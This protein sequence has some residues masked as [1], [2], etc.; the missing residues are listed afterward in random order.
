MLHKQYV[1]GMMSA[2]VLLAAC[3]PVDEAVEREEIATEEAATSEAAD[4]PEEESG[5]SV[6]SEETEGISD[7]TDVVEETTEEVATDESEDRVAEDDAAYEVSANADDLEASGTESADN[8]TEPET[9]EAESDLVY[10]IEAL[11]LPSPEDLPLDEVYIEIN[12]N[13]PL[14]TN[15][16][17]E[18]SEPFHSYEAR[19]EL[20]RVGVADALLDVELMPAEERGSISHVDPTGWNQGN[21]DVVSGNWLYNRSHLIGHQMTG[22]DGKNNLMTGTR[23][24]NVEGMLP[25]ENFVASVVEDTEMQVRYRVTPLFEDDNMLAHGIVMEGFSVDDNGE[26]LTFNVFVPNQQDGIELDYETGDH[27]RVE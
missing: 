6:S 25:F 14:F 18:V 23:Q 9:E 12:D 22:Y 17:L 16:E 21:Y 13:V 8:E 24:F 27:A 7:D 3:E 11:D 20:G 10:D 26:T 5:N 19:D 15:E 1:L 2:A 4:L